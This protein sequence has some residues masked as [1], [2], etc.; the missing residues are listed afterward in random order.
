MDPTAS[1]TATDISGSDV[2][3]DP[4]AV[5]DSNASD[6]SAPTDGTTMVTDSEGHQVPIQTEPGEIIIVENTPASTRGGDT[7]A[8]TPTL[9]NGNPTTPTQQTDPTQQPTLPTD[10]GVIELPFVPADAL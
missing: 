5:A 8:T 7:G 1:V 6:V 2:T 4:S 3:V 9:I 10:N